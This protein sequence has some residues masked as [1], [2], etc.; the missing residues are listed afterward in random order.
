MKTLRDANLRDFNAGFR[1]SWRILFLGAAAILLLTLYPFRFVF[2]R[3]IAGA[4]SP[5]LLEGSGKGSGALDA[6]L[7]VLLFVP[8]GFGLAGLV[9]RQERFSLGT[10]ALILAAGALFSYTIEFLQFFIPERDSGWEDVIMNSLGFLGGYIAFQMSRRVPLRFLENCERTIETFATPR[11]VAIVLLIYFGAWFTFSAHLQKKTGLSNWNPDVVLVVGN[12][13]SGRSTSGW[14]GEVYELE[15]WDH[16]LPDKVARGITSAGTFGALDSGALAAY[17]FSGSPPF[18]DRHHFLPDLEWVPKRQTAED[19]VGVVWDG[20]SW[21]ST[22][23]PIS[24]LV[25]KVRTT[26]QFSIR[27]RCEPALT[28]TVDASIVSIS[29]PGG[30]LDMEIRQQGSYVAFWFR[31]GLAVQRP[32][33]TWYMP[34][35]FTAHEPRDFIFSYNGSSLSVSVDGKTSNRSYRL[36]P[37]TALAQFVRR[38]KTVE[39]QGYRYVFYAL[40]FF[41]AG[42]LLGFVWRCTEARPFSGLSLIAL[43]SL[44]PPILLEIILVR[45]GGQGVSPGNFGLAFATTCAGSLWINIG[46]TTLT[47]PS[48]SLRQTSGTS[49]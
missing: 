46:G 10:A 16:A 42:C 44:L 38:V 17:E 24:D 33:M 35:A 49:R 14:D 31:N 22:R 5:F 13:A 37:A 19:S 39:L 27:V 34:N 1:W 7:N 15:F 47:G 3:H 9:R 2:H 23:I 45:V 41:P 8:A 20:K 21:A 30:Q 29:R 28:E 43:A 4:A 12:S 18:Q 25:S 48:Q 36:G 32:Q 11:N 40:M 6:L 26:R